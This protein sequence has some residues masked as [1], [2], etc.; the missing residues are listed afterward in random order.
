MK[1]IHN[2]PIL[3]DIK[4]GALYLASLTTGAA[5]FQVDFWAEYDIIVTPLLKTAS[6]VFGVVATIWTII[7][8]VHYV[9]TK[10]I[11]KN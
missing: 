11:G 8:I 1:A 9:R 7:R 2:T 5:G 4:N 10:R 6:I 3:L